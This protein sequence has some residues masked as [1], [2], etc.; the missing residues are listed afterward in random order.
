MKKTRIWFLILATLLLF[1]LP[2]YA[3][4]TVS[5]DGKEVTLQSI[6][7]QGRILIP[8]RNT[9]EV[10]GAKVNYLADIGIAIIEKYGT[11]LRINLGDTVSY[12]NGK[13]ISYDVPPVVVDNKSYVP[14]RFLAESMNYEVTYVDNKVNLI[15]K[16]IAKVHFI[17]VG[18]GDAI[19]IQLLNNKNILI[20]AG[21]KKGGGTVVTY[22]RN[23]GVKELDLVVASKTTSEHMG[24]L[25]SIFSSFKIKKVIDTN[26][27][28]NDEFYKGYKDGLSKYRIPVEPA[29]K[30][31]F[32][33]N[34]ATFSILSAY[35]NMLNQDLPTKTIL[36]SL[37]VGNQSILF[38]SDRTGQKET[39]DIPNQGYN[40]IKVADHAGINS[41]SQG[42]LNIVKPDVAIVTSDDSIPGYPRGAVLQRISDSG[43][44]LYSTGTN[45]NII[46]EINGQNY[47]IISDNSQPVEINIEK[48]NELQ[49]S[50]GL[51]FG[52]YLGD[53]R[54]K[55]YHDP[56]CE[57]ARTIPQ[58]YR[59]WFMDTTEAELN[60][61]IPDDLCRPE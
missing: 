32:E 43:A 37:K 17:D 13:K 48:D 12:L 20:D 7:Y 28:S 61:F 41:T 45:G 2:A 8:L 39:S 30:Q 47:N 4:T 42:L 36:S 57:E 27:A 51:D 49:I 60:G 11:E 16:P 10:L 52:N 40:I 56:N 50:N 14:L 21:D 38:M 26:T 54:N 24:G 19:L 23:Q 1:A 34:G 22:L 53:I 59:V 31:I 3:E 58:E 18:F 15:S 33:M 5:V 9:S 46:V 35:T 25:A 6:S 55:I 29:N 44:K